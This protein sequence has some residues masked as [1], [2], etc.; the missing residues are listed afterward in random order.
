MLNSIQSYCSYYP[1]QQDEID[2]SATKAHEVWLCL[3]LLIAGGGSYLLA[4]YSAGDVAYFAAGC[5]M[6]GIGGLAAIALMSAI[7][8]ERAS[9]KKHAALAEASSTRQVEE[10]ELFSAEQVV[11]PLAPASAEEEKEPNHL[12]AMIG[13]ADISQDKIRALTSGELLQV[14]RE[15]KYSA[16]RSKIFNENNKDSLLSFLERPLDVDAASE[17]MY[18]IMVKAWIDVPIATLKRHHLLAQAY[19]KVIE[20][21]HSQYTISD[22]SS[23]VLISAYRIYIQ[24]DS[25]GKKAMLESMGHLRAEFLGVCLKQNSPRQE[26]LDSFK[27][28]PETVAWYVNESRL[29]EHRDIAFLKLAC[30]QMSQNQQ[31]L[32]KRG[33]GARASLLFEE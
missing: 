11:A 9:E 12:Y 29:F 26:A 8:K 17:I 10:P 30:K 1:R 27:D 3:A 24:L 25:E 2:S 18:A 33:L 31:D 15:P 23:H 14:I 32:Y 7:C 20:K 21:M 5:A 19:G 28:Y 16:L 13:L 6:T 22:S 4:S